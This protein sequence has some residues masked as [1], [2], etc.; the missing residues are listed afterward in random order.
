MSS[1]YS[2][3]L[4]FQSFVT[5]TL[6]HRRKTITIGTWPCRKFRPLNVCLQS[7]CTSRWKHE[8]IRV[9]RCYNTVMLCYLFAH[10]VYHLSIFYWSIH[11]SIHSSIHL[12]IYT[13][14]Q[15]VARQPDRQTC[16]TVPAQL[17]TSVQVHATTLYSM[18]LHY[19]PLQYNT[20]RY[21][22]QHI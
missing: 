12:S 16:L 4:S 10:A 13:E 1:L 17:H 5:S 22:A 9:D 7:C 21:N 15:L 6:S 18:P 20:S 11:L 14:L 2:R 8:Q 3:E 19:I